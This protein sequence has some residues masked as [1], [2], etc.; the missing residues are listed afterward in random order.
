MLIIPMFHL[1]VASIFSKTIGEKNT[2]D[3]ANKEINLC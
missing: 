1:L 3:Q 2:L